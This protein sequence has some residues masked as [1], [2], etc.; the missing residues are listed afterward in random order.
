MKS[1]LVDD[2]FYEKIKN[3]RKNLKK[4]SKITI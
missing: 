4:A 3:L 2:E 1:L